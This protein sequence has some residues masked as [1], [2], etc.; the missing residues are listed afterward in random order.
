MNMNPTMFAVHANDYDGFVFTT[1]V[2]RSLPHIYLRC[3]VYTQKH[4][5]SI[6]YLLYLLVQ[7]MLLLRM[8]C[9]EQTRLIESLS[10]VR[11][12]AFNVISIK[13][14]CCKIIVFWEQLIDDK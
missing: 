13:C 10:K 2:L 14:S 3:G 8:C 12:M 4:T 7:S 5:H 11:V 6:Y 1:S 9:V